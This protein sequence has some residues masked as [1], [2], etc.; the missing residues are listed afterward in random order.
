MEPLT[1]IARYGDFLEVIRF[2]K[3]LIT[4]GGRKNFTHR[5]RSEI[6]HKITQNIWRAKRRLRRQISACIYLKGRPSF[7]T[8]TYENPQMDMQ[9]AISEWKQ[10]TRR[11]KEHAPDCAFVRVPERHKS[12][13]VHFH[14][15]MWGLPTGLPCLKRKQGNRRVHACPPGRPCERKRR[16]LRKEWRNGFVDVELVRRENAIAGYMAK[17]LTKGDPDWTLFGAHVTQGNG[18]YRELIRTAVKRGIFFELSTFKSPAAVS[19]VIEDSTEGSSVQVNREF[20]TKWLGKAKYQIWKIPRPQ[21]DT[22]VEGV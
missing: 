18:A 12:G 3:P 21:V 1:K 7:A 15:V 20:D 22:V 17:Y 5:K 16:W 8:F 13:A 6:T 10:F 9:K 4:S 11:M 19:F 14:A 2:E